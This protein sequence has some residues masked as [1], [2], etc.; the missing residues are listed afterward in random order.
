[1]THSAER[2]DD[3][4][5]EAVPALIA[6]VSDRLADAAEML[7]DWSRAW[8]RAWNAYD[9]DAV[10]ALVTDDFVYVDPSMFG[11]EIVGKAAFREFLTGMWTAF[12]DLA[13]AIPSTPYVPLDG[14]GLAVPWRLTGTFTG[15]LRAGSGMS[16]APN[17]RRFE[18]HGIDL[19]TYR[20]GL[21]SHWT[22]V[23]DQLDLARQLGLMP[24]PNSRQVRYALRAQRLL[25]PLFTGGR[26][27]S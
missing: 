20:E 9:A 1:M 22:S 8:L 4:L 25:T 13:M 10:L 23:A 11:E 26:R 7:R 15:E 3:E 14:V 12:P 16:L 19:Y 6:G 21:L 5:V 17:G 24:D 27:K 18:I 2:T